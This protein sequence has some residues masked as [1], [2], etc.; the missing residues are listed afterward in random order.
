MKVI[1]RDFFKLGI[2]F[3]IVG[4][5][6]FISNYATLYLFRTITGVK[7]AEFLAVIVALQV[8]FILHNIWTY[9][10]D[11]QTKGLRE[12]YS[13]YIATNLAGSG[14]TFLAFVLIEMYLLD[15]HLLSLAF[16]ALVGMVWNFTFNTFVVWRVNVRVH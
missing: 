1:S 13:Q 14:I 6:G 2:K 15:S 4:V 8:T 11:T 7:F 9:D 16:A 3:G 12:K 10:H 5:I